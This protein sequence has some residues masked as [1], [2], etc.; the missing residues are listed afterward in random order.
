M[1]DDGRKDQRAES[2]DSEQG[3][4]EVLRAGWIKSK[5]KLDY[6]RQNWNDEAVQNFLW[7]EL[8]GAS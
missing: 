5:A 3:S 7:L 8:L 1:R 2:V 6:V 4:G